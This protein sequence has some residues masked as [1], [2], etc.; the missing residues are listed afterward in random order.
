MTYSALSEG[1]VNCQ[2]SLFVLNGAVCRIKLKHVDIYANKSN[3]A[4]ERGGG[5]DKKR[6]EAV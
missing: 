2:R 4:D 6:R 3:P 5:A 1:V